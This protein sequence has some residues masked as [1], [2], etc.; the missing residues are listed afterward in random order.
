MNLARPF[1]GRLNRVN[2]TVPLAIM[3]FDGAQLSIAPIPPLKR[4]IPAVR[5]ARNDLE[6]VF[7]ATGFLTWGVG[8]REP[9]GVHF[10]WSFRGARIVSDLAALGYRVT[11]P[12][13]PNLWR[14]S[15]WSRKPIE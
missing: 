4:V 9:G 5:I 14:L 10:F 6:D 7:R 11:P 13:R 12:K 1:G 2:V 15:G 8:V 3:T